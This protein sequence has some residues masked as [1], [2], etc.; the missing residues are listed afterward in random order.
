M[1]CS[2][3]PRWKCPFWYVVKIQLSGLGYIPVG[4]PGSPLSCGCGHS[5][6]CRIPRFGA[7]FILS[8]WNASLWR[9]RPSGH[10]QDLAISILHP[11]VSYAKNGI[12]PLGIKC[13]KHFFGVRKLK[14]NFNLWTGPGQI[15]G[16]R[17]IPNQNHKYLLIFYY[18]SLLLLIFIVYQ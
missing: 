14:T 12:F 1:G 16:V 3:P 4:R 18:F 9:Y 5:E 13:C 17:A 11:M 7:G 10:D 2:S 6:S 8:V 15:N